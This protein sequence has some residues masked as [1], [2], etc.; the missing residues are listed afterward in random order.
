MIGE[1][2]ASLLSGRIDEKIG[3]VGHEECLLW[4]VAFMVAND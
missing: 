1:K 4:A 2:G 3:V